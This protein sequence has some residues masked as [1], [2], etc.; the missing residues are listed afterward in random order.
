[1]GQNTSLRELWSVVSLRSATL[2]DVPP[3]SLV[4]NA[5]RDE[6]IRALAASLEANGA[7]VRLELSFVTAGSHAAG[8]LTRA[9]GLYQCP[10]C[11]RS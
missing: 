10:T 4:G 6:G 8:F 2:P 3:T 11:R 7:I 9:P 1:M 5:I